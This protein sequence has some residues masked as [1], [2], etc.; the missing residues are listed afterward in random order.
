MLVCHTAHV[1]KLDVAQR[2]AV[3]GPAGAPFRCASVNLMVSPIQIRGP[4]MCLEWVAVAAVFRER[5]H[6][7]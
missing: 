4:S 3:R 7:V 5:F 1:Q 2:R 6:D